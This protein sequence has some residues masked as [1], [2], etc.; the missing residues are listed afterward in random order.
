MQ[1]NFL[2]TFQVWW[3][4]LPEVSDWGK[5]EG[6]LLDPQMNPGGMST[7]CQLNRA[8]VLDQV[9]CVRSEVSQAVGQQ[10]FVAIVYFL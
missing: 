9:S 2:V 7:C 5:A 8:A 4:T 10:A 6:E 3:E 1:P